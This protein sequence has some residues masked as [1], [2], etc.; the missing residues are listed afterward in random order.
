MTVTKDTK[1][2]SITTVFS[3]LKCIYICSIREIDFPFS[4][5]NM[6]G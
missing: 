1:H 3:A 4:H 5:V 6:K 2:I